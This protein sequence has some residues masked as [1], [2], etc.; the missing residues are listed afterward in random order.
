MD[1]CIGVA[2]FHN[3]IGWYKC[4]VDVWGPNLEGTS[5]EHTSDWCCRSLSYSAWKLVSLSCNSFD[6]LGQVQ[7]FCLGFRW[8]ANCGL[9]C[10]RSTCQP[11]QRPSHQAFPGHQARHPFYVGFCLNFFFGTLVASN[12]SGLLSCISEIL[13]SFFPTASMKTGK[14]PRF[15]EAWSVVPTRHRRGQCFGPRLGGLRSWHWRQ[16]QL[17]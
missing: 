12:N 2:G 3:N 16:K 14:R 1:V 17:P 15:T 5:T 10:G 6:S 13:S 11:G 9:E 8:P 4:L 7:V